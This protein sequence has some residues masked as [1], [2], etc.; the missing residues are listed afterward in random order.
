VR[1]DRNQSRAKPLSLPNIAL[2]IIKNNAT[3]NCVG[4]GAAV[5]QHQQGSCG[6][7]ARQAAVAH[8]R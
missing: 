4:G 2:E 6:F 8:A 7:A 5:K 3:V 1:Y